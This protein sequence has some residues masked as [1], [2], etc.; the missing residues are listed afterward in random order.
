MSSNIINTFAMCRFSWKNEPKD[1]T[2][3]LETQFY[4]EKQN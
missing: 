4:K 3:D 2:P 1:L